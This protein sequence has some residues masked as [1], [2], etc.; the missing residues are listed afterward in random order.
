MSAFKSSFVFALALVVA[1]SLATCLGEV[2]KNAGSAG[3]IP[4]TPKAAATSSGPSQPIGGGSEPRFEFGVKYEAAV[5]RV[6]DGDTIVVKFES[7]P[8]ERVRLLGVDT[9]EIEEARNRPG[10]Y[11][12][13]TNLTCLT[14][15]GLRAKEF[16]ESLE[17]KKIWLEFDPAAGLRDVYGRLLAYVYFP[18][19]S[20]DFNAEL[21]RLGY[22]RVYVEGSFA[23]KEEYLSLQRKAEEEGRGLWGACAVKRQEG[24]ESS[25]NCDPSYPDVCIPPPPPDLDCGDVPYRNFRVLPPDPH[26]FDSDGDGIGCES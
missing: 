4:R 19:E 21:V 15:W 26:N 3:E 8:V 22:A 10:E 23:K 11:D 6:V 17:G 25:E 24:N 9:P 13:I 20:S 12:G 2:L 5:L 18:N 1:V 7:G 16:A 14:E